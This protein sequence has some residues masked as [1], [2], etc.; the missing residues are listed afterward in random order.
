MENRE[1]E[2]FRKRTVLAVCLAGTDRSRI[3]AEELG[4]RGYVAGYAGVLENKTNYV[5][6]ED[7]VGVGSVIFTTGRVR[8]MFKADK[9]LNRI[10]KRNGITTHVIDVSESDKEKALQ[11]GQDEELRK[12]I[13]AK[14]DGLG[15]R[16][17]R[18]RNFG[19]FKR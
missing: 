12:T 1:E 4:K 13:T 2:D 8:D 9:R 7:L 16:D 17:I 18:G 11:S 10:L 15:Y 14:L 19:S 5:T 6:E 3:I